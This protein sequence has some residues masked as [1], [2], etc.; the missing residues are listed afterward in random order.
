[1]Q[2]EKV[3]TVK[4]DVKGDK[5]I[6]KLKDDIDNVEVKAGKAAVSAGDMANSYKNNLQEVLEHIILQISKVSAIITELNTHVGQVIEK[7]IE[8][9][10]KLAQS[11]EHS[12]EGI[13]ATIESKVKELPVVMESYARMMGNL[14]NISETQFKI[15]ANQLQKN[16]ELTENITEDTLKSIKSKYSEQGKE[17]GIV[18]LKAHKENVDA[19]IGELNTLKTELE[20]SVI[21]TR[22]QYDAVSLIYGKDSE[23]FKKAQEEKAK[24]LEKLQ[25][26]ITQINKEI[27][28]QNDGYLGA[29]KQQHSEI[30]NEIDKIA[31]EGGEISKFMDKYTFGL[32]GF[33]D[34]FESS[35]KTIKTEFG[36]IETKEKEVLDKKYEEKN[37]KLEKELEKVN[38]EVKKNQDEKNRLEKE[39]AEAEAKAKKYKDDITNIKEAFEIKSDTNTNPENGEAVTG[40]SAE[41]TGI[42]GET[43]E[44]KNSISPASAEE[45]EAAQNRIAELERLAEI[46][47]SIVTDKKEQI[48]AADKAITESNRSA[49]LEQMRIADEKTKLEEEKAKKQAAIEEKAQKRKEKLEKLEKLKAKAQLI[50]DIANATKD[51]AKGVAVAWAKGPILGPPLAAMVAIQGAIQLGVMSQQLKYFKDGGLLKGKRHSQGGMRIEGTNIEV[52]GGE[53]VVNRESTNKN[54]GLVRYI[55]SQRRELT[56]TDLNGFFAKVSQGYEPPFRSQFEAGGQMPVIESPVSINNEA[57]VA[58]I[59]SIKIEPKVAVTDILRVQ[60]EMTHV[61]GWSGI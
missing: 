16:K 1:M 49:L 23:E 30:K 59:K 2:T 31:G 42:T 32:G 3:L 54:L 33:L 57:L 55:N 14:G 35:I 24:E 13:L 60:D 47:E 40:L 15:L 52:E 36:K 20:N 17:I 18:N 38:A 29:W 56:S 37:K 22:A 46:E 61:D 34:D 50:V 6:K 11:I 4:V 53:Y 8:G 26:K 5:E 28:E 43:T 12:G 21:Q 19:H 44:D 10:E 51:I 39:Q 48:E 58:A 25:T 41:S 7:N 27:K 9:G 45:M